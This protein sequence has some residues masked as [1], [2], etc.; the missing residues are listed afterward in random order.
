MDRAAKKM[1]KWADK[2]RHHIEYK[3][4]DMVFVKLLPKK[5]KS[6]RSVHKG[7]VMRYK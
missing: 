3:V 6:L 7:L 2:K 1:K 5:F 4:G